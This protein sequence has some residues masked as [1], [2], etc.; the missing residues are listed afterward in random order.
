M[1]IKRT[2][3]FISYF[4]RQHKFIFASNW[5][6]EQEETSFIKM[7]N[8][9][10]HKIE[11]NVHKNTSTFV[12]SKNLTNLKIKLTLPFRLHSL[13]C[14][15]VIFIS[16]GSI[17]AISGNFA[18]IVFYNQST[19]LPSSNL[20]KEITYDEN[21]VIHSSDLESHQNDDNATYSR[22]VLI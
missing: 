7:E 10:N 9:S 4:I 20:S 8:K 15:C 21:K 16:I 14:E 6:R 22:K 19:S 2:W 17:I 13:I 11:K 12:P 5:I 18:T 3:E 1:L